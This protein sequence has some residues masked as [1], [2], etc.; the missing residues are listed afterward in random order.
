M[1][2]R[3][4][5]SC[6]L[7]IKEEAMNWAHIHLMVNHI[8]VMGVI[9]GILLLLLAII[10]KSDELKKVSLGIFIVITLSSLLVYFT[11][12]PSEEVVENLPG[13]AESL[14]EEH[15][16]MAFIATIAVAILGVIAAMGL[17]TSYSKSIAKK[18]VT[19]VMILSI[20]SGGLILQ[21]ATLGG[22]IRHTEIRKDF[23]HTQSE[24]EIDERERYHGDD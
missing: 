15:E 19:A 2:G 17:I 11:G 23:R 12:E 20:I 6:S 21:T 1:G 14:I 3:I 16:E 10:K 13:V 5:I 4:N 7:Y 22:E 9:F 8:P 18:M 24:S